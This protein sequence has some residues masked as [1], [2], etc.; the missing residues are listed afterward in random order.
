[1]LRLE[2][3]FR[4]ALERQFITEGMVDG[5]LNNGEGHA[6]ERHGPDAD[7]VG[8]MQTTHPR[9]RVPPTASRFCSMEDLLQ[10]SH[11]AVSAGTCSQQVLKDGTVKL[12]FDYNPGENGETMLMDYVLR[13]AATV[14]HEEEFGGLVRVVVTLRT[15]QRPVIITSFPKL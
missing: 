4:E 5:L 1:M 11:R 13:G 2:S 8:R 7:I 9:I 14:V 12:T 3:Y 15:G 6:I 10:F